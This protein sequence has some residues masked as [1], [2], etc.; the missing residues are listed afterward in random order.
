MELVYIIAAF[1]AGFIALRCKL[2]PLVGFLIAGFA[3]NSAG[4]HSTEVLTSL[5]DLGVTLLLF[6]IGL[7]LDVK[8][9]LAKEIW[10]GATLHNLLSTG[11]FTLI[12]LALKQLGIGMLVELDIMQLA[13][14]AFALSFSSTVFAIKALQEK[15]ELNATYGTLA[16]GILVM[17]DVF[18]V[19]FLTVSTG[20]IPEITAL[21]LFALPL[22]RPSLFKILDR[23]GHGEMLVLYGIFLALVAGAGLFE[24]VGMKADL[25]ALIMGMML[26]AH[27]KASELSK[28]LF[29]LKELLLVCFFLNIGLSEEP[30]VNGFLMAMVFILLLPIK[31]VLYYV[32]FNLFRFRVRTSLL[33]TLTLFNYSEFGL[34]VSGLAYNMGLLPGSFLVAIAIAVSISFLLAAPLNSISHRIYKDASKWLKEYEPEKLNAGDR[35][36]D[37]GDKKIMILGM[38][39][40]GTGAYDELV[41]RYG[42]QVIGIETREDS[43]QG[44]RDEGRNVIHGDATDPD[45][46]A[47]VISRHNTE[48][49]LLAMPHSQANSF[50]LEQIRER[51]YQGKIAAIAKYSDDVDLLNEMGVDAAFNIYNEA[52]SGFA[53]HVCEHLSPQIKPL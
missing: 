3:L 25:G 23:A 45:F 8:T 14:L 37:L 31:G 52:G 48:L 5:A 7:K 43:V 22:L 19:I 18:A 33:G 49:I 46:W 21:G 10:G 27:P 53:R 11:L 6:S 47:R 30:T 2:P 44:H 15:G 40:I 24:A 34:I 50:A 38:G 17:Q 1:L 32:I 39:R 51:N 36:I 35:L 20:K 16:I 42:Q 26:A 4:Y 29:N 12:L 9:L 41:Q 28:S 13:L